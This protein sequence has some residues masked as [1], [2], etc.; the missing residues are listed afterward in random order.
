MNHLKQRAIHKLH[1][2]KGGG[3]GGGGGG[4]GS[5]QL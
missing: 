4:R 1:H 2:V 3:G 5:G